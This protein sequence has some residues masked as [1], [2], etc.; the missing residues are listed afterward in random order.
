MNAIWDRYQHLE[1]PL[2]CFV[3]LRGV[4]SRI[5][6]R[7]ITL[8]RLLFMQE[9]GLRDA[10]VEEVFDPRLS[11]RSLAL[12]AAWSGGSSAKHDD[13]E[14]E[15]TKQEDNQERCLPCAPSE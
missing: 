3:M 11:P 7:I 15:R 12:V 8:D 2:H 13:E 1:R 5:I 6:E 14:G 9:A 10:F 4:F